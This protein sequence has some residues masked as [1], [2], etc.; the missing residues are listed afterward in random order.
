MI[1]YQAV[2]TKAL[3]ALLEVVFDQTIK[4]VNF[5][6]GGALNSR[7]LKQLCIDMDVGFQLL[8]LQW[9]FEGFQEE[10]NMSEHMSLE[11]S[12]NYFF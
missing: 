5:V 10:M 2:V 9:M 1:N 8:L 3:P 11:M 12:S 7:L 6:K 4:I